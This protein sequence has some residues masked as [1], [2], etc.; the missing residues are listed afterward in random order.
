MVIPLI[1]SFSNARWY[2]SIVI[3]ET[4]STEAELRDADQMS[5]ARLVANGTA[6]TRACVVF[7]RPPRDTFLVSAQRQSLRYVRGCGFADQE[8]ICTRSLI[9]P[10]STGTTDRDR[11]PE[12]SVDTRR[13][14][15]SVDLESQLSRESL[16]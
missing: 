5:R 11:I 16:E 9:D 4:S 12:D 6:R 15:V 1:D 7:C 2:R 3:D 10:S 8:F 14:K 13:F